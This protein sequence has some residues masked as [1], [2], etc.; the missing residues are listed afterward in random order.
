MDDILQ[1]AE[2]NQQRARQVIKDSG[3][4]EAWQSI[5][6]TVNLVGS[7]NMGLLMKHRD[8]DF[9]IYTDKLSVAESYAAIAKLAQNPQISRVTYANLLNEPDSCLEWHAWYRETNG[10][11]W[12]IDMMHI[13]KGSAYDGYFEKV[14]E[15]IRST[16]TPEQRL[17]VLTLKYQTPEDVKIMGIEYYLA[18]IRDGIL[19]FDEFMLWRHNNPLPPIIEWL[20]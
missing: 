18:V 19:T 9:H 3:V 1:L 12:Q 16:I 7:L 4:I 20:P 14:A 11:E 10:D 2:A 13:L 15:R 17:T 5:G 6:A 8:I